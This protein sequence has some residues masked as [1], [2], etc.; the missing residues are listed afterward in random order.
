MGVLYLM[1]MFKTRIDT[2]DELASATKLPILAEFDKNNADDAIRTLRTNLLLNLKEDQKAIMVASNN[3]GDGKTFIAKKLEESLAS[4]GKK[5]TF[6]NGDLRSL[7]LA[8]G[9][10]AADIIAGAEFAAQ[11]ADAKSSSDYIIIDSPAISEYNDAY[12]LA[13]FADATLYVVKA[14]KTQKSDLESLNSNNNIP[15]PL[16]VFHV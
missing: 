14:G 1:Q 7:S 11:L 12:Q 9:Q 16:I 13:A 15:N 8:K 6:I 4:I 3:N 2:R 10:H 5:V